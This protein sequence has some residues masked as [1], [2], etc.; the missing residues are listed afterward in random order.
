MR[1]LDATTSSRPGSDRADWRCHAAFDLG[2]LRLD[3]VEVTDR[4]GGEQFQRF[5]CVPGELLLADAGYPSRQGIAHVAASGAHLLVRANWQSLPLLD[6]EGRP[7][8][9]LALARKAPAA[10]PV[11]HAVSTAPAKSTPAVAGRLIILRKSPQA[12]EQAQR[13][14]RKE[15]S[16]KGKPLEE[17][18]LEAAAY[19]FLFTTLETLSPT[20]ALELY[21]FR[22][23]V[24]LAFK[25]LK[26]LLHLDALRAKD[27]DLAQTYLYAKLLAA[28]LVDDLTEHQLGVS[29]WG[30][31]VPRPSRV[32]LAR[33]EVARRRAA[34]RGPRPGPA[35]ARPRRR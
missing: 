21:R 8:D 12:V 1:V 7:V 34:R 5:H 28:I 3:H 10:E 23:Q 2:T 22:W 24:E 29:P 31:A 6:A 26:S 4:R 25:R 15:R 11:L 9:Y 30:Y 27:P 17:R 20:Q 19:I 13:R 18:S 33:P 16:R 35:Q 14:M 32:H